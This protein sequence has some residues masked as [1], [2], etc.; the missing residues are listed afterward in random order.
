M[1]ASGSQLARTGASFYEAPSR[2]ARLERLIERLRDARARIRLELA[3]TEE[4][5]ELLDEAADELE[6]AQVDVGL[7]ELRGVA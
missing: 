5:D 2:T 1:R 3:L 4:L 6:E 7:S